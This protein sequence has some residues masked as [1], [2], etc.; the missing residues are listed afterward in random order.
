M[1]PYY[2]GDYSFAAVLPKGDASADELAASLDGQALADMLTK[3]QPATVVT[4]MPKFESDYSNSLVDALKAMGVTDAFEA[5]K[6]DFSGMGK[7]RNGMP[8]FVSDVLHK[9]TICVTER[10]TRAAAVSAVEMAAGAALPEREIVLDRPFVYMIVDN[11]TRLPIFLG[12]MNRMEPAP[13]QSETPEPSTNDGTPQ[14]EAFD[15]EKYVEIPLQLAFFQEETEDGLMV[16]DGIRMFSSV[17]T[18]A[19]QQ[20]LPE[21]TYS[22]AFAVK[23]QEPEGWETKVS[24]TVYRDIGDGA[25]EALSDAEELSALPAGRY[26]LEYTYGVSRGENQTVSA[27]IFWLT[28]E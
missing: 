5:K 17:E 24:L 3:T 11:A 15:G 19:R 23:Y 14:F 8:V 4:T 16:G 25:L 18:I 6:A 27:A 9:T 2:G 20:K 1:K 28:V 7:L 26:A 10:G 22:P 12:V 13:E 21:I